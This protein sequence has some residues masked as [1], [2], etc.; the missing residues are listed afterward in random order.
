MVKFYETFEVDDLKGTSL[1]EREV[2]SIHYERIHKM[3]KEVFRRFNSEDH[4]ELRRFALTNV[5]NVDRAKEL[6]KALVHM[7]E[8]DLITVSFTK[9][10]FKCDYFIK[11]VF[12][13]LGSYYI[14]L[15]T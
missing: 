8:E 1:N 15:E 3:Q 7:N 10:S 12:L 11:L 6:R 13:I 2:S 4:P 9:I 5:G 14:I